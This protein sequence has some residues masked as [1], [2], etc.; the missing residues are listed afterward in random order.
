M[1][2]KIQTKQTTIPVEIGENKFEFD[3]S[4][5][6]IKRFYKA[7][8][9]M[10]DKLEKMKDFEGNVEEGREILKEAFNLV[11][12]DGAFDKIYA[13]VPSII[14]LQDVFLQL[15]EGIAEEIDALGATQTQK[16]KAEKYLAKKRKK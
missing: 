1:A 5:E 4:D 6:S 14:V 13:E 9:E 15:S 3:A 8:D 16:Q 10:Q 11:L 12:G 2:I 7:T